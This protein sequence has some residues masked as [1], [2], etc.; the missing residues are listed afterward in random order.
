[1]LLCPRQRLRSVRLRYSVLMIEEISKEK[2]I[3]SSF[4]NRVLVEET[5]GVVFVTS[6]IEGRHE[7]DIFHND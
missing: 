7:R 6:I 1:M 4:L 5:I 2:N 3:F